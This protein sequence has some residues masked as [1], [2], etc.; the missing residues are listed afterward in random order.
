[1]I[2]GIQVLQGQVLRGLQAVPDVIGYKSI[3]FFFQQTGPFPFCIGL[4]QIPEGFL[5]MRGKGFY[6]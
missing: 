2:L 5:A 3:L 4:I 6:G 1:M